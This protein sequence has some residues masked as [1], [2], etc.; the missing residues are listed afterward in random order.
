MASIEALILDPNL[1]ICRRFLHPGQQPFVGNGEH[2]RADTG[3]F[4]FMEH[5]PGEFL[6]HPDNSFKTPREVAPGVV[7]GGAVG[8][9][10]DARNA[11][12][13]SIELRFT[14]WIV[15]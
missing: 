4:D 11:A 3:I 7:D 9:C 14:A 6:K 13:R 10:V 1:S 2:Q 15:L 5:L 8:S 12:P